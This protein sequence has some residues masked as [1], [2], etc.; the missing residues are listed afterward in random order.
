MSEKEAF[1]KRVQS[2]E[3]P[4]TRLCKEFNVS[5]STGYELLKRYKME[6][7]KG[8]EERS[9]APHN[10]PWKIN[11]ALEAKIISVRINHPAW[12]ARKILAYLRRQGTKDLPAAS[13]AT[14]VLKRHGYVSVEESLKRQALIRFERACPN[15]LW[16]M[17]FKGHFQMLTKESCYPLTIIDD[18]SRYSLCLQACL[19]E[20]RVTVKKH[21][22]GVFKEYGMPYQINVDNG[23]PWG[24]SKLSPYTQLVVWL[25]RL[26][27]RVSHSRPRHPQT[28][29]KNERFH[30][31][32]KKEVLHYQEIK[33]L[34]HAQRVFNVWR[35]EYNYERPHEALEMK[36]PAER[37]RRSER[38]MPRKLL[39][40][41][42]ES[43]SEL[44][45]VRGNGYISYGKEEYRVGEAFKGNYV[46]IKTDGLEGLL[47]IYFGSQ[48]I[49]RYEVD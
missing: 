25:M 14:Q 41:E 6:G 45:K 3:V 4:F 31:T 13:T 37:Y 16:Q 26:G 5:R 44:R 29:G 18:H 8:L 32:L 33:N 40:L 27:I 49:Y 12:G 9:R 36:V 20:Q 24:N 34:Y 21:L 23:S 47:D 1:L 10:S 11:E 15:D 46:E 42:Y 22:I 7:L 48:R 28:N 39:P 35:K 43:G 17:D 19:N 2:E 38:E 30:Q